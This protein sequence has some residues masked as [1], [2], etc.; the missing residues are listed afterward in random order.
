MT[1]DLRARAALRFHPVV[2]TNLG[3]VFIDEDSIRNIWNGS[4]GYRFGMLWPRQVYGRLLYELSAQG[5]RA[6]ALD[7]VADE[8][9]MILHHRC[10]VTQVQVRPLDGHLGEFFW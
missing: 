9:L 1:F 10:Y 8:R 6:V 7:I 3:F 2:A 4:L 5:A